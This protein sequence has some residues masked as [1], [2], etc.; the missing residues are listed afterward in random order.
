MNSKSENE[1][2]FYKALDSALAQELISVNEFRSKLGFAYINSGD[3]TIKGNVLES[4][5]EEKKKRKT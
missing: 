3:V 1:I 4:V 2:G 5:W